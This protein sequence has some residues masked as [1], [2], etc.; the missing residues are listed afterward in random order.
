MGKYF[1]C[2]MYVC[3]YMHADAQSAIQKSCRKNDVK[4]AIHIY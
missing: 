1:I 3:M 2:R 4:N